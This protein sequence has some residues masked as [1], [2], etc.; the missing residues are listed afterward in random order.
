MSSKIYKVH[1][2]TFGRLVACI[3]HAMYGIS[4]QAFTKQ[5]PK[6]F[7]QAQVGDLVFISEK[8]VSR[9]ALFGPFYIINERA[10]IAIS[11][12]SGA[13]VNVNA[14]KT[15]QREI[16][17]WVEMEKRTW[18]L[19]FDKTLSDLISIVWPNDWSKL[20][21]SLPSWGLVTGDD[22]G[23]LVEFAVKNQVI[24]REF[25]KRHNVF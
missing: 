5:M 10:P 19:L 1:T 13:W 20:K 3:Q 17:Y 16:A 8:E 6:E 15:P 4:N 14:R 23:K 9:N 12:R 2:D 24:A 22:A 25:L 7:H 21:V 11:G 18:C